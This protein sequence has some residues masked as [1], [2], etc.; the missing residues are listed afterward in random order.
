MIAKPKLL[1]ANAQMV[2]YKKGEIIFFEN[3]K[4]SFY[5][6]IETGRVKMMSFTSSGKEVIQKIFEAGS[7]FG[8]PALLGDFPYPARAVALTNCKIWKVIRQD[9]IDLLQRD[10]AVHLLL[11]KDI[12]ERMEYKAVIIKMVSIRSAKE[13]I[14]SFIQFLKTKKKTT[15]ANHGK[16]ILPYTRQ[17]LADSLGLRVETVIR[18]V[19]KLEEEG[20]IQI[21]KRKIC[22]AS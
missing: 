15:T 16:F 20:Q 13:R 3:T 5:Y 6:Q 12:C 17:Q 11:T 19:K 9:F 1:A 18:A 14:L 2:S 4:A 21:V 7:T 22:L 10:P 8:E